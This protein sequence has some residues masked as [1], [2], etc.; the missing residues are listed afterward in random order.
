MN[1]SQRLQ[2]TWEKSSSYFCL[3]LVLYNY[4]I[5]CGWSKHSLKRNYLSYAFVTV[6]REL[7]GFLCLWLYFPFPFSWLISLFFLSSSPFSILV[8]FNTFFFFFSPPG[9]ITSLL[10]HQG[11]HER[12]QLL[13]VSVVWRVSRSPVWEN[14][15]CSSLGMA[16]TPIIPLW[17][18]SCDWFWC[19]AYCLVPV[20][21]SQRQAQIWH[22]FVKIRRILC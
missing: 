4:Y 8:I 12:R 19:Q 5:N 18:L 21:S 10:S 7:T 2:A 11:N 6:W 3:A 17:Y 1:Q 22:R 13:V 15:T 20:T 14:G 16:L 9:L